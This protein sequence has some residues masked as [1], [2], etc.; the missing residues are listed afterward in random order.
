MDPNIRFALSS[1]VEQGLFT[2]LYQTLVN[3]FCVILNWAHPFT[4]MESFN[5]LLGA[6]NFFLCVFVFLW[7][8]CEQLFVFFFPPLSWSLRGELCT[9]LLK[10]MYAKY[11][12]RTGT[13]WSPS[14][15][16]NLGKNSPSRTV[17]E[18]E[19]A[20]FDCASE[21]PAH[22]FWKDFVLV[23]LMRRSSLIFQTSAQCVDLPGQRWRRGGRRGQ[24]H[25]S[26]EEQQELDEMGLRMRW[27]QVEEW[28]ERVCVCV[29]NI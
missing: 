8:E 23:S 17:F 16:E 10:Y 14:I 25:V 20:G 29:L 15:L 3:I 9:R 11:Y 19:S 7:K 2:V 4:P 22:D 5:L 12:W 1:C 27:E 6:Q 26:Y 13:S 28:E 21:L 24:C 18:N